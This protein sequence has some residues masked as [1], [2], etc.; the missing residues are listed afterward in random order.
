MTAPSPADV[1]GVVLAAGA[2]SRMGMPKALMRDAAGRPWL[3][4]AVEML[5]AAGCAPILVVLGA[6]GAEA[7]TLLPSDG[8]VVIVHADRWTGGMSQSL[9]AGLGAASGD[10]ALVTLVDL[11]DLPAS[12]GR[13]VLDAGVSPTVLRRAVFEGRPGHP[14][15]IGR[16]HWAP[17]AH[18][19][20][21]D[22][23]ARAYLEQHGVENVECGMLSDGR[24]IDAPLG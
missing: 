14:V 18:A 16:A 9:R 12:V 23:G 3:H 2:G 19:V 6:R 7:Q 20:R 10:A 4:R 8:S 11:P 21:G 17:I 22:A 5:R 13:S 24:D 1:C 15:L